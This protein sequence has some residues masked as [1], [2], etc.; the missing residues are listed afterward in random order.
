MTT[1]ILIRHGESATNLKHVFNGQ[2][3]VELTEKGH[4][5]AEKTAEFVAENY[6]IDKI[7][8]SDLQ[9]AYNTAGY[10]AKKLG[11]EIIT[12]TGLREINAGDWEGR[13]YSYIEEHYPKDYNYWRD[14]IGKVKCEG[15]ESV[16]EM[17]ERF[18][19][20]L[21]KI[22]DENDGKT[23]AVVAHSAPIRAMSC[24]FNNLSIDEMK[25]K[26]WVNNASVSIVKID[27]GN[28]EVVCWGEDSHLSEINA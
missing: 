13:E 25:N 10:L 11:M 8:S 6:K 2:G 19:K 22:A 12:D 15:G 4:R 17:A 16:L 14:D 24:Y 3:D 27:K 1:L 20:T 26:P 7:Y 21:I 5:Q 23:V 28:Y 18:F 9:R